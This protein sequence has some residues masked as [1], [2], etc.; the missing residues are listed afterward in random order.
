MGKNTGGVRPAK[1]C[2]L[3][4]ASGWLSHEAFHTNRADNLTV[5]S[6]QKLRMPILKKLF[7]FN[8]CDM[9]CLIYEKVCIWLKSHLVAHL[10]FTEKCKTVWHGHLLGKPELSGCVRLCNL[11]D[12]CLEHLCKHASRP[13]TSLSTEE[14]KQSLSSG[15]P[16]TVPTKCNKPQQQNPQKKNPERAVINKSQWFYAC[17]IL[18]VRDNINTKMIMKVIFMFLTLV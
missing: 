5:F 6:L 16:G 12:N 11:R 7:F 4:S 9:W 15:T 18:S 3:R 13:D 1:V 2:V 10:L 8:V 17:F 14:T